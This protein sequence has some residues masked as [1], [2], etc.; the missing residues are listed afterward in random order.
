MHLS[1]F[2]CL[3]F[4]GHIGMSLLSRVSTATTSSLQWQPQQHNNTHTHGGNILRP[5][6]VLTCGRFALAAAHL[7]SSRGP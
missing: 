5:C 2:H 3:P 4:I 7:G 1:S 6:L